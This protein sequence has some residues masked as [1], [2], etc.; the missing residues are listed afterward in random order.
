LEHETSDLGRRVDKCNIERLNESADMQAKMCMLGKSASRHLESL[1]MALHRET[2]N[3][4]ELSSKPGSIAFCAYRDEDQTSSEESYLTFSGC[5]VNLGNGLI[6][7]AGMFQCPEPGMYLFTVTVCTFDGKHCLLMLRKND[8]NVCTLV[9]Q[10]ENENKGKTMISQTCFLELEISDRVQLF[11]A[12][13]SAI[14]DS[15]TSHHTQFSG[16]LMRASQETFKAA[17]KSLAEDEN[18][19]VAEGFRGFTPSRGFTPTRGFTPSRGTTPSRSRGMTPEALLPVVPEAPT[20]KPPHPEFDAIRTLIK[21]D[22]AKEDDKQKEDDKPQQSYS[23]VAKKSTSKIPTGTS[24]TT[25]NT[26]KQAPANQAAQ[27]PPSAPATPKASGGFYS[28]LKR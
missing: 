17:S 13:G 3:L 2:Q 15:Y 20:Q 5:T 16:V 24:K 12:S 27:P 1:K 8:K 28:F 6:P 10:N 25:P 4:I 7:K 9:D 14:A 22:E 11:S 21:N 26:P 19:S 18:V 23:S